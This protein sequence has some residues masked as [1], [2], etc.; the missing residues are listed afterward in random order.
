VV[1]VL[2][3]RCLRNSGSIWS[4]GKDGMDRGAVDDYAAPKVVDHSV[5]QVLDG[6]GIG[7]SDSIWSLGKARMD[8]GAVDDK[9]PIRERSLAYA[10]G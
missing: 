3:E 2:D 4:L 5:V 8:R 6:R 9:E 1:Q 7:K 10:A